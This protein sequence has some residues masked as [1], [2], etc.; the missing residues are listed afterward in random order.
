MKL[1]DGS[2]NMGELELVRSQY[3]RALLHL[4]TVARASTGSESA[5]QL[6]RYE[7]NHIKRIE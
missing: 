7:I 2:Y 3:Q 4:V 5:L 1:I 6:P